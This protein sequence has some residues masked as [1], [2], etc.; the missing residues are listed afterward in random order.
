L[1]KIKGILVKNGMIVDLYG[2][3]KWYL[4][5]LLH[6][7][8]GPAITWLGG[9]QFWYQHGLLHR[10]DG[11]AEEYSYGLKWWWLNGENMSE[12]EFERLIKLKS[13]W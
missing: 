11:P 8:E 7:E 4:N 1:E 6:R 12:Q 10:E 9:S 13:F 2:V 5:D 3:K